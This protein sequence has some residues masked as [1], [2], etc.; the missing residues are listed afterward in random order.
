M[1][2]KHIITN[3]TISQVDYNYLPII[4]QIEYVP[5]KENDIF[6]KSAIIQEENMVE[7]YLMIEY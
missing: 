7:H 4:D 5:V 2:Y 1:R 3:D 6:V